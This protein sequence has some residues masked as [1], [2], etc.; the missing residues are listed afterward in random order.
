[1]SYVA[2]TIFRPILISGNAI[3]GKLADTS[4]FFVAKNSLLKEIEDLKSQLSMAEARLSNF[5]SILD[6][7]IQLKE[8]LGRSEDKVSMILSAILGKPN[9]SPYDTLIVDVGV[10]QSIKVGNRVFALG[11]SSTDEA[12]GH[13]PIGR[14]A[15]VYANSSK[16]IL[17]S[18]A[19]EKTQAVVSGKNLF[20]EVVGR[21]GGNF[22]MILPR[23]ITL[24]K[25]DTATL[26][27]IN[28]YVLGIV[29]TI[30]S[31]PRDSFQKALLVSPVNIQEL[32]F[33]EV[34]K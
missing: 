33:V 16:V 10:K 18:N 9:Q 8:A 11:R 22:E 25:G 24:E 27:G 26:P 32:K 29:E 3:R 13:L 34:E 15:E 14:V 23:D 4:S 6:E 5:N 17:F 31:D 7:N 19:G 21:G 1:M 30:I 28:P 20:L 12:V 2:N